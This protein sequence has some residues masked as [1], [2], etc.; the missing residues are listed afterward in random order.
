MA[1]NFLSNGK[2][3]VSPYILSTF[4][5]SITAPNDKI[6]LSSN[7]QFWTVFNVNNQTINNNK[8]IQYELYDNDYIYD[9]FVSY[10]IYADNVLLL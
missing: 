7:K 6:Y 3:F 4:G 2:T 9:P 10:T 1:T 5:G 8:L